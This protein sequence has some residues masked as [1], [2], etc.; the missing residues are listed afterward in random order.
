MNL[1]LLLLLGAIW[2]SSYLFIKVD[3][4]PT[5]DG[6][7]WSVRRLVTRLMTLA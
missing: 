6:L 3:L 1:L 7:C 4:S 5:D 2:G